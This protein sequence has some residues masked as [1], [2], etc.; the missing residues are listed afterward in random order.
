MPAAEQASGMDA[1]LDFQND[2]IVRGLERPSPSY[3]R[4][5]L[6]PP[7]ARASESSRSVGGVERRSRAVWSGRD[8]DQRELGECHPALTHT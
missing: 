8:D 6:S 1:G 2:Q 4:L 3:R 5:G 7:H